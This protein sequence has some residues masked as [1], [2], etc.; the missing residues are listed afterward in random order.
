MS[1]CCTKTDRH[2]RHSLCRICNV[3]NAAT[4]AG[5]AVYSGIS[6]LPDVF[7]LHSE[8][9]VSAFRGYRDTCADAPTLIGSKIGYGAT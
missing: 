6:R 4:D 5:G 1:G 2:T 9:T 8:C 7:A 3:G